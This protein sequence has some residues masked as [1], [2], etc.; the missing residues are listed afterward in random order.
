[1][2]ETNHLNADDLANLI[3]A[4]TDAAGVITQQT[5]D[6]FRQTIDLSNFKSLAALYA[7]PQKNDGFSISEDQTGD[8]DTFTFHNAP[9]PVHALADTSTKDLVFGDM[10]SALGI[11]TGAIGTMWGAV[12]G[13][14]SLPAAEEIGFGAPA[15]G[16]SLG[17]SAT[18][19]TGAAIGGGLVAGLDVLARSI[20]HS[21]A[22]TDLAAGLDVSVSFPKSGTAAA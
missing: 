18:I 11:A 12:A 7:D 8:K 13:M 9:G 10:K 6:N 14:Y 4:S 19:A 2:S 16:L 5:A 20:E 21:T 15:A 22:Q 3:P 1:M 17:E